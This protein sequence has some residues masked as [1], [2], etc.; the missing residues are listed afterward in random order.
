MPESATTTANDLVAA[1]CADAPAP[2]FVADTL[3]TALTPII[4][5]ST[6]LVTSELLPPGRPFTAA[7]IRTLP[8]GLA[9]LAWKP[10]RLPRREW[11]RLFTLA[12]LNIGFFQ[13]MLFVAAYRLPGGIAAIIGATMPLMVIGL[14]WL[15]NGQRPSLTT[16]LACL[17]A[18]AGMGLIFAGPSFHLDGWGV[19]AATAGT[20]SLALGT[21][22]AHRWRSTVPVLSFTGWQL[23]VGGLVLTPIAIGFEPPL[24]ALEPRHLAGFAYLCVVGAM[25]SYPLW[26]RGIAKLSPRAV[27]PLGLLS[28]LT[29]IILGWIVLHQAVSL[30]TGLGMAIVLGAVL[31]L[32]WSFRPRS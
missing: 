1:P 28:P 19:L 6:Y 13:A 10:I 32:Q 16:G 3:V 15:L 26:F 29:A 4:W 25:V 8:A 27:A 21:F 22:L 24:P 14:A 12:V 18:I 11:G 17:G 5:G 7:M 30:R 20:A 2:R 31:F 9:L 23:L